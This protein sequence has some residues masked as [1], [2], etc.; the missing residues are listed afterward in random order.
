[1]PPQELPTFATSPVEQLKSLKEMGL[2]E[3]S[4]GIE[5]GDD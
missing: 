3:I 5:S 4:L 2:R 1:M